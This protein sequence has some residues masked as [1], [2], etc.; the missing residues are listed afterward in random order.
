MKRH[1]SRRQPLD[2]SFLNSRLQGAKSYD[3]I[4]GY[5]SSSLL[6]IVG[7]TLESVHG[8]I[9]VV[10][11]STLSRADVE[12]ANAAQAAMRRE[13]CNSQPEHLGDTA[14]PRFKRHECFMFSQ[15]FD[16]VWWLANQ[17][18]GELRAEPIGIYAGANRS[19][20]IRDGVVFALLA[21]CAEGRGSY[22]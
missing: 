16:S 22:R 13:W 5:F 19:G 1:S 15:Y 12:V 20:V 2:A 11:N 4:A 8:R 18:T 21:R 17:L 9:R 10:C 7:E 6:E 3:R 14:K